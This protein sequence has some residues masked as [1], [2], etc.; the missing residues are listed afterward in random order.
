MAFSS[1]SRNELT[2]TDRHAVV[3][4]GP[5]LP[6]TPRFT[7][8]GGIVSVSPHT[9][10]RTHEELLSETFGSVDWLSSTNDEYRFGKSDR[11]LKGFSLYVPEH[12]LPVSR[13]PVSWLETPPIPGNLRSV[14]SKNFDAPPTEFRWVSPDGDVLL[15]TFREATDAHQEL[16]RLRAA[17]DFDLVFT[18]GE[19]AGWLLA[20]PA[21]HLASPGEP[22]PEDE[23]PAGLV[24]A[25][26]AFFDLFVEPGIDR[27]QDGDPALL[28]ELNALL[29]RL[30]ALPE[31]PRVAVLRN[32]VTEFR[33][34]WY[35]D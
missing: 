12:A 26:R 28:G 17:P 31:D 8:L 25:L 19:Y 4:S 11:E 15:C 14:A 24:Q 21:A 27:M 10:Q 30:E 35:D 13:A 5:P 20:H 3:A 2:L 16:L 18:D 34:D 32:R 29:T 7:P 1:V 6:F 23:P 33:E 9:D 22:P